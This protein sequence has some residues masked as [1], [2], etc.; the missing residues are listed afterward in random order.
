MRDLLHRVGATEVAVAKLQVSTQDHKDT[1]DELE[2]RVRKIEYLAAKVIGACIIGS[3][4]GNVLLSQL[5][6]CNGL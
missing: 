4:L 1:L 3:A 5:M 2:P 6:G